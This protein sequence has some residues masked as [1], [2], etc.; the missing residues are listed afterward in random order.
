VG[1]ACFLPL[2][3]LRAEIGYQRRKVFSHSSSSTR[4][5][6]CGIRCAPVGLL[7]FYHAFAHHLI[8]RRL[9]E[10]GSD[11]LFVVRLVRK[12]FLRQLRR[13]FWVEGCRW[14]S[15]GLGILRSCRRSPSAFV[16]F[17]IIRRC[18]PFSSRKQAVQYC[19]SGC[20]QTLATQ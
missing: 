3:L 19:D 17:V 2:L 5:R 16:S 12:F 4:V 20:L 10:P 18:L 1:S 15:Y 11:F 8:E 7:L 9:G 13:K 6:I 14:R